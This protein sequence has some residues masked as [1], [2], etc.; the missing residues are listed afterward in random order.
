MKMAL[1]TSGLAVVTGSV[2]FVL[3][4]IFVVFFLERMRFQART[5]E[6]IAETLVIYARE[7]AVTALPD[8]DEMR[9]SRTA[10]ASIELRRLAA[11]LNA[12]LHTLRWY[13]LFQ[14]IGLVI[15]RKRAIEASRSLIG[16][17]NI[18][19]NQSGDTSSAL[20]LR[21]NILRMLNLSADA[22]DDSVN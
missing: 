17:S 15:K 3:G 13:Q 19:E 14:T 5:V 20:Q 9:Q 11:L 22:D 2:V 4:Q 18:L 21:G 1:L 7:I 8:G 12:S 6:Q 10:E 16:I